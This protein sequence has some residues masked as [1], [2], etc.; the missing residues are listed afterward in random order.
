VKVDYTVREVEAQGTGIVRGTASDNQISLNSS[1]KGAVHFSKVNYGPAF[2]LRLIIPALLSGDPLEADGMQTI[3]SIQGLRCIACQGMHGSPSLGRNPLAAWASWSHKATLL[4][5]GTVFDVLF[6]DRT[7]RFV[8]VSKTCYT[9]HLLEN[10]EY[11]SHLANLK[12]HVKAESLLDAP[13]P[14]VE[15]I[16][17]VVPV[18]PVAPKQGKR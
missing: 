16:V 18:V 15:S 2:D 1:L 4:N 10:T 17:P 5:I 7:R 14:V 8:Y 13:V 6:K 12:N 11:K 3:H 9:D